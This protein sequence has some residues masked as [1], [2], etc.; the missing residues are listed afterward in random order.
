MQAFTLPSRPVVDD[1]V[2]EAEGLGLLVEHAGVEPEPGAARGDVRRPAWR[3]ARRRRLRMQVLAVARSASY[4]AARCPR[5]RAPPAWAR[6][7]PGRC[8]PRQSQLSGRPPISPCHPLARDVPRSCSCIAFSIRRA[9]SSGP[10]LCTVHAV[11]GDAIVGSDS[12][13]VIQISEPEN[14]FSRRSAHGWRARLLR[15]R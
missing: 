1:G 9:A 10:G 15:L 7:P 5:R 4:P 11:F 3:S 8:Q 6:R 14:R 13:L 2:A 12:P